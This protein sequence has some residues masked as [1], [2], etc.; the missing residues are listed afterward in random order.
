VALTLDGSTPAKATK[1]GTGTTLATGSFTAPSNALLLAM[2]DS[3]SS[4]QTNASIADSGSLTWTR[5]I[6]LCSDTVGESNTPT[7]TGTA[8]S[9]YISVWYA[10]TTSSVSRTVTVTQNTGFNAMLAVK[11]FTD[12]GGAPTMGAVTSKGGSA[13]APSN[14]V[15]TTAANSWVWATVDDWSQAG[16]GTAGTGQTLTDEYDATGA[17]TAHTWKQNATT[18]GSGTSVTM[19]LTAPASQTWNLGIVEVKANSADSPAIQ[20]I[21][22]PFIP[23]FREPGVVPFQLLGD[24]TVSS[25]TTAISLSDTG[26]G[27]DALTVSATT[28]L[29]DT[30]TGADA[31]SVAATIT[32]ADTGTG[33]DALTVATAVT[34][35]DTGSGADAIS[36]TTS[37]TLAETGSGADALSAAVTLTLTDTG[38]GTDAMSAGVPISL[39]D[40]GSGTDALSVTVTAPL[41]DTGTGPDA[42]TAN[43]TL[44][45][46][47]NGTGADALTISSSLTITD[48]GTG[49]DALVASVVSAFTPNPNRT[50]V[51][52]AQNRT[53]IVGSQNRTYV[54]PAQNRTYVVAKQNR[55]YVVPAEDRTRKA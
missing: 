5:V 14:T 35:A 39:A 10:T 8:Q 13:S 42:L 45:L 18:P 29:A 44:T 24:Q 38:V 40:T 26:A 12:T 25:G 22:P 36:V 41:A 3:D 33:V 53:Y 20:Q 32:L 15:T 7:P 43:A 34:L 48:T 28:T 11:V 1:T 19:N 49:V 21:F 54:V 4:G 2:Y 9:G 27:A 55:T 30:G 50:F 52:P 17:I 23:P 16:L 51:V 6:R 31:L 46:A 47:E 37:T